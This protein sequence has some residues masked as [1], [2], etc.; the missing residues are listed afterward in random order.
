[1]PAAHVDENSY[2]QYIRNHNIGPG[3]V[4]MAPGSEVE[5]GLK[6]F[7]WLHSKMTGEQIPPMM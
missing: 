4:A 3:I 1:M 2:Q 5:A 7:S 6:L